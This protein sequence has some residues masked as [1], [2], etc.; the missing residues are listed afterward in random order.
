[1]LYYVH[2]YRQLAKVYKQVVIGRVVSAL[3]REL[4]YSPES[5]L[6]KQDFIGMDLFLKR[7]ENWKAE[8]EVAGRK[9][10]VEYSLLEARATRTEGSGKHRHTV[11]IFKGVI[12]RLDFNKDF[13]GHTVVVPNSDSQLVGG[14]FGESESRG[15]K[16]LCRMDS[17]SFE[18]TFSVYSTDQQ[19]ARYVL[20]PK[21][22][23]LILGASR[24]FGAIRCSFQRSTLF[25]TIPS[26]ANRFEVRLWG[27][28]M[29]PEGAVGELAECVDLADRLIDALDLETRIWSKV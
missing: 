23:E 26:D 27:A 8:D 7:A 1:M 4:S 28:K 10:A 20:T 14:L 3:G 22:M 16:A 19:E 2:Q 11:T 12:V 5:R 9:N 17:V 29:T 6:T 21:L 18:E 13:R 15:G 24:S 25:I